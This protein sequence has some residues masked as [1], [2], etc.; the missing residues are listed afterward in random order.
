MTT[1]I[2]PMA[3][4]PNSLKRT[5]QEADLQDLP[6]SGTLANVAPDIGGDSDQPVSQPPAEII[7]PLQNDDLL[8]YPGVHPSSSSN[9]SALL[10]ADDANPIETTQ[11]K[12]ATN[13]KRRKFTAEEQEARRLEREA[14]DRQRAEEKL[15]LE[16]VKKVKEAEKEERRKEK[17]VQARQRE[18]E[19]Q[20]KE[21]QREEERK[22]KEEER[23]KK[24]KVQLLIALQRT[25]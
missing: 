1:T 20:K 25:Y 13:T 22:K 19:R 4:S 5:Y 14:K 21:A 15:R 10:L 16:E 2:L 23:T 24:D 11:P 12:P 17:E 6:P 9:N 3:S 8:L 18:E 7:L